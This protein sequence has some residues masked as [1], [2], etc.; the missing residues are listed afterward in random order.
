MYMEKIKER[1]NTEFSF[2]VLNLLQEVNKL[3]NII[4]EKDSKILELK[5]KIMLLHDM[6]PYKRK[7]AFKSCKKEIVK[8]K[9]KK[10]KA[11]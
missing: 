4:K 9:L 6:K 3:K 8:K 1:K 7:S 11:K 2:I 10:S 5:K